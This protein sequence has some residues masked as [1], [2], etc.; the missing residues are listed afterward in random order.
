MAIGWPVG[1]LQLQL[2]FPIWQGGRIAPN[3]GGMSDALPAEPELPEPGE[4]ALEPEVAYD[5]ELHTLVVDL[6]GLCTIPFDAESS[7]IESLRALRFEKGKAIHGPVSGEYAIAGSRTVLST[8]MLVHFRPSTQRKPELLLSFAD[9]GMAASAATGIFV[10]SLPLPL[11]KKKGTYENNARYTSTKDISGF[12][13]I[14]EGAAPWSIHMKPALQKLGGVHASLKLFSSTH[15]GAYIGRPLSQRIKELESSALESLDLFLEGL[16]RQD[17]NLAEK[18]KAQFESQLQKTIDFLSALPPS[19]YD[20]SLDERVVQ[21]DQAGFTEG[22]PWVTPTKATH[23]LAGEA[24]ATFP[25]TAKCKRSLELP[26]RPDTAP[27]EPA[28]VVE[29][30]DEAENEQEGEAV[31]EDEPGATDQSTKRARKPVEIFE[32]SK[33]TS[34]QKKKLLGASAKSDKPIDPRTGKAYTRG[35]YNKDRRLG[36]GAVLAEATRKLDSAIMPPP[37]TN[38]NS[39]DRDAVLKLKAKVAELEA[40]LKEAQSELKV[41]KS[42]EEYRVSNAQLQIQQAMQIQIMNKYQQGL[43]DGAMLLSGRADLSD[44]KLGG[45][46]DCGS[47]S[48]FMSR[49]TNM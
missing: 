13:S 20:K 45:N 22:A 39:A 15:V 38:P 46:T 1:P 9:Y 47:N 49:M 40:Q 23:L 31:D 27:F 8:L 12:S 4:D 16:R 41:Q 42:V 7:A 14:N 11:L 33:T 30:M 29:L 43:K 24:E 48:S 44:L 2:K 10:C 3:C 36:A 26:E 25:R 19:N 6:A 17:K 28:T 35:P 32:F 37:T 21:V 34:K 18:Q 5:D